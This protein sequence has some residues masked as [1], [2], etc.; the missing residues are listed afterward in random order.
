MYHVRISETYREGVRSFIDFVRSKK[1]ENCE[2][3]CPCI[4]C[5][6]RYSYNQQEV[7]SH[8]CVNGIMKTYDKW[9]HHGENDLQQPQGHLDDSN[10]FENNV[11]F[12]FD[13]GGTED[14]F[15]TLLDDIRRAAHNGVEESE[16]R[17]THTREHTEFEKVLQNLEEELYPG[18]Q[19][20]SIL[21]FVIKLLH[22]KVY[23]HWTNKSIDMLLGFMKEVLPNGAKLPKS[24]YEAKTMLREIGLGYETIHA[25]K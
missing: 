17:D 3:R 1:G 19:S 14:D 18:C 23:N 8:L 24:Y 25:C 2:I 22:L 16:D 13:E 12:D 10:N 7:A 4:R 11:T 20:H 6:N 5:T 15:H 21:S 9:V